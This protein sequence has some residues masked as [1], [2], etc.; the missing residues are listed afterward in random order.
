MSPHEEFLGYHLIPQTLLRSA[1]R[2]A[3]HVR[4][5]QQTSE[6]PK[7]PEIGASAK[8]P[9]HT[10]A[11]AEMTAD[12]R[13]YLVPIMTMDKLYRYIYIDDVLGKDGKFQ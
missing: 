7:W 13:R 3:S 8:Q 10:A 11:I 2:S 6:R 12:D 9:K 4:R 1:P 5:V